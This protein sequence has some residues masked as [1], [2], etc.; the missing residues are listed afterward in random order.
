MYPNRVSEGTP[1]QRQHPTVEVQVFETRVDLSND[2][3]MYV[4]AAH[5]S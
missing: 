4:L 1:R 3:Y 2:M 5:E